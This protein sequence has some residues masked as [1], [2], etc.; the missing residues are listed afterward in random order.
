M[1]EQ[2]LFPQLGEDDHEGRMHFQQGGAPPH[3]HRDVRKCFNTRFPGRWI[4]RAVPVPWPSR[5]PDLTPLDFFLVGFCQRPSVRA[6]PTCKCRIALNSNY[7]RSCRSD[8]RD[9]TSR[10]GRNW[11]Q[12]GRLPQHK[13]KSYRIITVLPAY[14]SKYCVRPLYKCI[15][16]FQ[17]VKRLLKHP[18]LQFLREEIS[19]DQHFSLLY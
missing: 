9:A 5:S 19:H 12:V 16:A 7:R 17:F 14:V 15:Y 18:V 6:N 2:F 3:Y 8:A 10:V 4:G 1:L 13:W 11:I